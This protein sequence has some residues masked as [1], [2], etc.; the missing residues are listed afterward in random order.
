MFPIEI[1]CVTL[2]VIRL[3]AFRPHSHTRART[4]THTHAQ[5]KAVNKAVVVFRTLMMP[6]STFNVTSAL[7]YTVKCHVSVFEQGFL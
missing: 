3:V 7:N 6:K 1:D 2:I 5:R 4:H